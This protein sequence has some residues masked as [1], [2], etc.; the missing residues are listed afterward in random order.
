MKGQLLKWNLQF[1]GDSEAGAEVQEVAEPDVTENQ[2][3]S[4]E[5]GAGGD[6]PDETPDNP[7]TDDEDARFAAVRRKAEYD[8]KLKYDAQIDAYN[9]KIQSAFGN[10][11]NPKTGK[12]VQSIDDYINAV[13]AQNR[14]AIE[15]QMKEKGIDPQLIENMIRTSPEIIQAQ[16]ILEQNQK[17]EA[18]RMLEQDLKAVSA[19]DPSIQSMDDLSKHESFQTVLGYVNNGLNLVDAFKLANYESLTSKKSE[20]AKQAAINAAKST[21]HM[22]ATSSGNSGGEE[23]VDIPGNEIATWREYFPGISDS[24]LKKKYNETL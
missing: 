15:G 16:Q 4:T 3:D 9:K 1:F 24:E 20:A 8:A 21:S 6:N 18:D 12:P 22:T 13:Q 23:L 17:A 10:L 5:S 14:A 11:Q 2:S 19:I 7:Q